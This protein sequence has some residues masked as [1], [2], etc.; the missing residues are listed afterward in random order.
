[1]KM[2]KKELSK[3]DSI[4][5]KRE[6]TLKLLTKK[7]LKGNSFNCQKMQCYHKERHFKELKTILSYLSK[8]PWIMVPL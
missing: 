8:E 3:T 6:L 1:M 4:F 2:I 7:K 5:R